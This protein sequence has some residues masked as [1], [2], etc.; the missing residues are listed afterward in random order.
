MAFLR[1]RV[2]ILF[3]PLFFLLDDTSL[4]DTSRRSALPIFFPQSIITPSSKPRSSPTILLGQTSLMQTRWHSRRATFV[5]WM[6]SPLRA[7]T[8]PAHCLCE[9]LLCLCQ[10]CVE[11]TSDAAYLTNRAD[12][13]CTALYLILLP[14]VFVTN[15]SRRSAAAR[16]LRDL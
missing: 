13:R 2:S 5:P 10:V 7:N 9:V 12:V 1:Y 3:S 16:D 11:P 6:G 8:V 4:Q 14:L 15:R